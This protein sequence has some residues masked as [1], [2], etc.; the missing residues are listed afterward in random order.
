[1]LNAACQGGLKRVKTLHFRLLFTH[2]YIFYIQKCRNDLEIQIFSA[3]LWFFCFVCRLLLMARY[4]NALCELSPNLHLCM[5]CEVGDEVVLSAI[6][7]YLIS[8]YDIGASI[9]IIIDN[10]IQYDSWVTW[11]RHEAWWLKNQVNEDVSLRCITY[12]MTFWQLLGVEFWWTVANC[13]FCH[14]HRFKFSSKI[15]FR[16]CL[17]FELYSSVWSNLKS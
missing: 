5:S 4:T 9:Q 7:R 11:Q 15:V 6:T 2:W 14:S 16:L 13:Y 8:C 17:C 12:V 10:V 1:M 3:Q